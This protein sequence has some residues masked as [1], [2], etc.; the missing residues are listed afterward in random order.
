[1]TPKIVRPK[2]KKL[3][4]RSVDVEILA[5]TETNTEKNPRMKLNNEEHKNIRK[6]NRKN[7][8]EGQKNIPLGVNF[9]PVP[10]YAVTFFSSFSFNV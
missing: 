6:N 3:L 9:L 10:F 7:N 4:N 8:H 2:T 5:D 1:L